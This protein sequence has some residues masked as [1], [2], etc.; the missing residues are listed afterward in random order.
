MKKNQGVSDRILKWLVWEGEISS[1]LIIPLVVVVVQEVVRR[2]LFNAP[3]IW[4]FEATTFL[5]GIH[6]MLGLGYTEHYEGHVRVD[7]ITSRLSEKTQALFGMLTYGL[8]FIPVITLF[9]IW[10]FKFAYISTLQRELNS[11]SWAP[12]I[13]PI[14]ILMALGF[15]FLWLR[16]VLR[17]LENLRKYRKLS[18]E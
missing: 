6:Y 7:I 8:M 14:K 18:R 2:Y 3:S 11:T 13:Y 16:G 12:P 15:F 5:Y 9:T 4:G 1:L 10:S 17:F